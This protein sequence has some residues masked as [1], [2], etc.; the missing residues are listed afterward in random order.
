[1]R[2]TEVLMRGLGAP[3]F[4]SG[5][6]RQVREHA[7]RKFAPIEVTQREALAKVRQ[8]LRKRASITCPR[9]STSFL[10]GRT[11]RLPNP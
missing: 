10:R 5:L 4:V 7:A 6:D 3:R 8:R 11:A 9:T 1:M 2:E